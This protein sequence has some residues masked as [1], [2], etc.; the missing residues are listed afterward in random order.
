MKTTFGGRPFGSAA[1]PGPAMA[2]FISLLLS[3]WTAFRFWI[4]MRD[5]SDSLWFFRLLGSF[6][7]HHLP[8][9]SV[10]RVYQRGRTG[11]RHFFRARA[12]VESEPRTER[13][14][15]R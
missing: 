5:I 4:A 2:E 1:W 11:R 9:H 10:H 8:L 6:R 15:E 7:F 13:V 3:A 12:A 14:F